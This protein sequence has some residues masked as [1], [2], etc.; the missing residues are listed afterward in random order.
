MTCG[1]TTVTTIIYLGTWDA[2]NPQVVARSGTS[3]ILRA[4]KLP[5]T[6]MLP[7]IRPL[8]IRNPLLLMRDVVYTNSVPVMSDEFPRS[9]RS[10]ISA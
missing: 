4:A 8:V 10:Q 6:K 9:I 5:A 2:A 1:C 7:G 3:S